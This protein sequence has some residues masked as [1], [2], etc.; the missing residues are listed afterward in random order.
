MG[1]LI[2]M[3]IVKP[4]TERIKFLFQKPDWKPPDDGSCHQKEMYEKCVKDLIGDDNVSLK[5][6][7]VSKLLVN[8]VWPINVGKS[9][10]PWM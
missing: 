9:D 3:Q 4:W 5:V 2:I 8:E 1:W 6:K 10:Y 7:G